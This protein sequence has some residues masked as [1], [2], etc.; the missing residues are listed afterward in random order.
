MQLDLEDIS[1]L[2]EQATYLNEIKKKLE[3]KRKYTLDV[4]RDFIALDKIA[5]TLNAFRFV[6][7]AKGKT[8][9]VF[10]DQ[11]V[12]REGIKICFARK[13]DREIYLHDGLYYLISNRTVKKISESEA[14]QEYLNDSIVCKPQPEKLFPNKV[15]VIDM[16]WTPRYSLNTF[17]TGLVQFTVKYNFK[18]KIVVAKQEA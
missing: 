15:H 2:S 11:K 18:N 4:N 16:K 7:I 8:E 13:A 17:K 5:Q 6:A 10:T 1:L 9:A 14:V 12:L 3:K